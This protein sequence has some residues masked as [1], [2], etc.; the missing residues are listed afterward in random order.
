VGGVPLRALAGREL[1]V[2]KVETPVERLSARGGPS[3]ALG[4][5]P[6]SLRMTVIERDI[7]E[8]R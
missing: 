2:E 6:A 7:A 8:V 4:W 3:T 1:L 5:R